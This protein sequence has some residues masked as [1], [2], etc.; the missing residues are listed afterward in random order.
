MAKAKKVA[1]AS[2]EPKVKP[3]GNGKPGKATWSGTL[4]FGV[5]NIPV[6]MYTAAREIDT[7]FHHYHTK[8]NGRVKQLGMFCGP[9]NGLTEK[10]K[11]EDVK[12]KLLALFMSP[13]GA[14]RLTE[15]DIYKGYEFKDG[16]VVAVS[17][18]EL[19]AMKPES[20]KVMEIL[21][22]VPSVQ[23]DPVF[24]E[25][26]FYLA[27]DPDAGGQGGFALLREAM[28]Q[29][30]V[31][32]VAKL[33]K[34]MREN[35]AIILPYHDGGMMMYTAYM[36]DEIRTMAFPALPETNP[37]H[38]KVACELVDALTGDWNPAQYKDTYRENV[39]NM[40]EAKRNEKPLPTVQRKSVASSNRDVMESFVASLELARS[41][42]AKRKSA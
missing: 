3:A 22:F 20:A 12:A 34:S 36:S 40:V 28:V 37:K 30:G 6:E 4:C 2:A 35:L 32:A 24:F 9:C 14:V 1:P 38:L 19:D 42:K 25:T 7:P 13:L 8:C 27:P 23:V 5:I 33:T 31:A 26:S 16:K 17:D 10:A 21:E 18:T 15:K 11:P 29:R 41:N 39:M